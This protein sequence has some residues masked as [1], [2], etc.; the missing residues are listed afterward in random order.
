MTA[1]ERNQN[2]MPDVPAP[3]FVGSLCEIWSSINYA[4][5]H[6]VYV[7]VYLQIAALQTDV[8]Q[9]RQQEQTIRESTQPNRGCNEQHAL[10][11]FIHLAYYFRLMFALITGLHSDVIRD[12]PRRGTSVFTLG[13]ARSRE[14]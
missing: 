14:R 1:R 8:E 6:L 4:A 3:D 7:R 10:A 13:P 5:Y 12:H 9:I 2:D 11:P